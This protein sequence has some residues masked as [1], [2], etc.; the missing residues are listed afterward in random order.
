MRNLL[1]MW[2][3]RLSTHWDAEIKARV[4]NPEKPEG[5]DAFLEELGL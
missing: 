1:H 3:E 4:Q 5:L 2:Q